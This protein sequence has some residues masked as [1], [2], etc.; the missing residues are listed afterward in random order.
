MSGYLRRLGVITVALLYR[1]RRVRVD[2]GGALR[3]TW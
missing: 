3:V 1:N 2:W